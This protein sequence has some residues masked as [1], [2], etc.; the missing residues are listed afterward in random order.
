MNRTGKPVRFPVGIFD[1]IQA[2]GGDLEAAIKLEEMYLGVAN[3][4]PP[5]AFTSDASGADA[6]TD[7]ASDG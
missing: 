6:M 3:P 1:V 7:L 5:N 2:Y 4:Q